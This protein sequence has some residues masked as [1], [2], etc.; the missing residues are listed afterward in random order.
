MSDINFFEAVEIRR[1]EMHGILPNMQTKIT[2]NG[3]TAVIRSATADE[4]AKNVREAKVLKG[5]QDN[6]R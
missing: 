5:G 1:Q 3:K 6:G 2:M 4:R